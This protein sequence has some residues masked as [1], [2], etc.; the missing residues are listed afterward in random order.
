MGTFSS[1]RKSFLFLFILFMGSLGY[2]G[3][4]KQ[5][6]SEP[7]FTANVVNQALGVKTPA[8]ALDMLTGSFDEPF[9][10]TT[11]GADKAPLAEV[12]ERY[13]K[14][15]RLKDRKVDLLEAFLQEHPD[16]PWAPSVRVNLALHYH[17]VGR[18]TRALKQGKQAWEDLEDYKDPRLK[19]L[20]SR[21]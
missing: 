3:F 13:R 20:N 5:G 12:L 2:F 8:V 1:R 14:D 10:P 6:P 19:A 21:A 4:L 7:R 15:D 17:R 9:I 11:K 18:F 16:S